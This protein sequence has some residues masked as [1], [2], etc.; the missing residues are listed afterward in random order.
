MPFNLNPRLISNISSVFNYSFLVFIR[1]NK[2]HSFDRYATY[3][4]IEIW[5]GAFRETIGAS[6]DVKT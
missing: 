1:E 5:F 3:R 2:R 6:A 4:D